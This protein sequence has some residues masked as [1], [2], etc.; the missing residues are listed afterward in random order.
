M[1]KN[2]FSR[3]VTITIIFGILFFILNYFGQHDR[4]IPALVGKSILAA[5][6]LGVLYFTLF[7]MMHTPELKF[8][9]GTTIPIAMLICV[10]IG[11][12]LSTL[13]IAII[14]GLVLGV[15]AG[16]IWVYI[17]KRKQGGG[18]K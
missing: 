5:L 17:D 18:P 8:K 16:Y 14:A 12:I 4:D 13:K 10:I 7:A 11:G 2:L 15:I 9:F 3:T 1:N 6:V